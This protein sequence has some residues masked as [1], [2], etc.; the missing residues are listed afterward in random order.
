MRYPKFTEAR[1]RLIPLVPLLLATALG[2]CIAYGGYPSSDYTYNYPSGYYAG[3]PRSYG[4]RTATTHTTPL[5]TAGIMEAAGATNLPK[6]F[7]AY[8]RK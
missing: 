4:T 7:G 2:G 5:G 3:Y 1:R 6:V 8:W